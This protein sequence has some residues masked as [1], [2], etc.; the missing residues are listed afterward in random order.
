[1][2]VWLQLAEYSG[3][4]APPE[5]GVSI[6]R[7]KLKISQPGDAYEQEAN[8]VAEQVTRMSSHPSDSGA[9]VLTAKEAGIDRK[10]ADCE[11]IKSKSK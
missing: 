8:S 7:R 3:S 5:C 9:S 10:C 1:V 6:I 4:N 11:R 2:K